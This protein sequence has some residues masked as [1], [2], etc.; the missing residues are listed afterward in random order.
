MKNGIIKANA[1][2]MN[3][4][5]PIFLSSLRSISSP[6]NNMIKKIA[7][8]E[9]SSRFS[10]CVIIPNNVGPSIIPASNSPPKAG[11]LNLRNTSPNNLAAA[12]KITMLINMDS[13]SNNNLHEDNYFFF[14]EDLFFLIL[15][16]QALWFDPFF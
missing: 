5:F 15:L 11:C 9:I 6:M 14:I 12:S 1:D 3:A 4:D 13:N 2:I 8:V 10:S 16:F 7:I